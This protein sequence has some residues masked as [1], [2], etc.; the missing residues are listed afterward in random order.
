[1]DVITGVIKDV[2]KYKINIL[3]KN[4]SSG[5]KEQLVGAIK[6][7]DGEHRKH[8]RDNMSHT[9]SVLITRAPKNVD[10]LVLVPPKNGSLSIDIKSLVIRKL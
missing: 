4:K 1:M 7:L 5:E 3:A 6:W 2:N 9:F 8:H 10:T